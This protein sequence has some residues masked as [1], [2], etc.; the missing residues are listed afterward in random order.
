MSNENSNEGFQT[1][2]MRD[3]AADLA[4]VLNQI[5]DKLYQLDGP[6]CILGKNAEKLIEMPENEG[7]EPPGCYAGA[8][9]SYMV[10]RSVF[11][12]FRDDVEILRSELGVE[13]N[14][15][16]LPV[17]NYLKDFSHHALL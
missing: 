16:P 10:F 17:S 15:P 8:A 2:E 12:R 3:A 9:N 5:A 11:Q 7:G 1:E 6:M 14:I 4:K 13:E